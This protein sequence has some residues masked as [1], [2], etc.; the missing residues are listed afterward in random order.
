MHLYGGRY[1]VLN[2]NSVYRELKLQVYKFKENN[3]M[4]FDTLNKI[5]LE[6]LPTIFESE[7]PSLCL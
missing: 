4:R 1:N 6:C 3:F 5:N 7:L 2:C